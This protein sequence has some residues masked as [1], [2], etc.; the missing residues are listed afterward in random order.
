[1][2]KVDTRSGDNGD[3]DDDIRLSIIDLEPLEDVP[4]SM[5]YDI[6]LIGV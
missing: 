1:M 4:K 5:N 3:D 6:R 2:D